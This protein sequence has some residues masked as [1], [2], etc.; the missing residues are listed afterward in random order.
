MQQT[1]KAFK[2]IADIAAKKL[3]D[4]RDQEADEFMQTT[5]Q[6]RFQT[7]ITYQHEGKEYNTMVD[8][9]KQHKEIEGGVFGLSGMDQRIN[10]RTV[11]MNYDGAISTVNAELDRLYYEAQVKGQEGYLDSNRY[12]IVA[13]ALTKSTVDN[14]DP[15]IRRRLA[16][17]IRTKID[18][19][20]ADLRF[21]EDSNNFKIGQEQS[22][23]LYE[24]D[25]GEIETSSTTLG[26]ESVDLRKKIGA[27]AER[28]RSDVIAGYINEGEA[29]AR[30]ETLIKTTSTG[31][32][33]RSMNSVA[34]EA[35]ETGDLSKSQTI[36]A[37]I[38][39]GTYKVPTVVFDSKTNEFS[40]VEAPIAESVKSVDARN[41]LA[42][43]LT[44]TVNNRINSKNLQDEAAKNEVIKKNNSLRVMSSFYVQNGDYESLKKLQG[45]AESNINQTNQDD[46]EA[47]ERAINTH[48]LISEN[49]GFIESEREGLDKLKRLEAL[50][51]TTALESIVDYKFDDDGYIDDYNSKSIGQRLQALDKQYTL[52]KGAY[53][54]IQK[55]PNAISE[56]EIKM[57]RGGVIT[58]VT[59]AHSKGATKMAGESI[60]VLAN[61]DLLAAG[62]NGIPTW[63]NGATAIRPIVNIGVLPSQV[64]DTL[65]DAIAGADKEDGILKFNAAIRLFRDIRENWDS[66]LDSL[67]KQM[68]NDL[69]NVYSKAVRDTIGLSKK[70]EQ[71]AEWALSMKEYYS[72]PSMPLTEIRAGTINSLIDD[73]VNNTFS[74]DEPRP[75]DRI[76]QEILY[77]VSSEVMSGNYSGSEEDAINE[78]FDIVWDRFAKGA[79]YGVGGSMMRGENRYVRYPIRKSYPEV[80]NEKIEELVFSTLPADVRKDYIFNGKDSEGGEP[81]VLDG[82]TNIRLHFSRF[83]EEGR[84]IYFMMRSEVDQY[85]PFGSF[86]TDDKF[87]P[88]ELDP[89]HFQKELDAKDQDIANQSLAVERAEFELKRARADRAKAPPQPFSPEFPAPEY[90][91]EFD[92]GINELEIMVQEQEKMLED[93][94]REREK[95]NLQPLIPEISPSLESVL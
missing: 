62:D 73:K 84:P 12:A 44:A 30:I 45:Q 20:Y 46:Y 49:L 83:N 17:E 14:S 64:V 50:L 4:E 1:S 7:M 10:E 35:M 27:V 32:I 74:P 61:G 24:A 11:R 13:D 34:K 39:T 57:V 65:G 68:G 18:S 47:L 90:Y 33:T 66:S 36:A 70:N 25:M 15:R 19:Q 60:D 23:A 78:A 6:E 59:A 92:E 94:E 55:R 52:L 41:A 31:F 54:E 43:K 29:N 86:I 82:K 77:A 2:G 8:Q 91:K 75:D 21:K 5:P 79:E 38:R 40:I 26:H 81:S 93:L 56:M 87:K 3:S 53:D 80:S 22:V 71:D 67:K 58:E 42:A 51:G 95:M 28:T 88:I 76:K 89:S 69:Y 9:F 85:S 37:D 72:Q 48:N 63:F 16:S